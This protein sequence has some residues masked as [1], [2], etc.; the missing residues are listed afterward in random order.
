V[1]E[2]VIHKILVLAICA[3][4][5]LSLFIVSHVRLLDNVDHM[6]VVWLDNYSSYL[7]CLWYELSI[8]ASNK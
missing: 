1:L 3:H 4:H 8:Y 7:G 5:L 6:F 2:V